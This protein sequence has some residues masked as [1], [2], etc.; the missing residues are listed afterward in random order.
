M[1]AR[2]DGV[3][4][5]QVTHIVHF[6]H[7][8]NPAIRQRA[9]RRLHPMLGPSVPVN[10]YEF[11]VA[12]SIDERLHALL[13]KRGLLP[14]QVPEGTRPL[15]LEQRVTVEDWLYEVLEISP[16]PAPA[17]LSVSQ[18]EGVKPPSSEAL[19][20]PDLSELSGDELKAEVE[21]LMHLIGYTE[22]EALGEHDDAG[23]DY[24]AARSGEGGVDKA[25]V[26]FLRAEKNVGVQEGRRLLEEMQ[27][28]QDCQAAYLVVT[29]DFTESCRQLARES[30]GKLVLVSGSDWRHRLQ[31]LGR[32]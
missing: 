23:A 26:R 32:E 4:F 9:E 24:T 31:S 20:R 29:S 25:L 5:T 15:D 21:S 19:Q 3:P 18:D 2:T 17:E 28:R 12:D 10:V 6:D 7:G 30:A 11:W 1:G 22:V 13:Q 14:D 27:A 16:E 8:W